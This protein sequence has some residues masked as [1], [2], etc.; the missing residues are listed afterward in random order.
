MTRAQ[1]GSGRG[2]VLV[3]SRSF[4]SGDQ[5]VQAEL[6]RAGLC[7]ARGPVDHDLT[8]LEEPL[9]SA[10][11]WIAGTGPVTADHLAAGRRLRVVARYGVGVDAV[12]L[13]AARSRHIVVTNTPGANSSSV[14]DHALALLLA[15]L[16]GVPAG[17]R[18]VRAGDWAVRRSHELGRLTVGIVGFGR[19]GQEVGRRLTGFGTRL[20]VHDPY[21]DPTIIERAGAAELGLAEM[22]ERCDL[23]TLHA[24]GGTTLVDRP[25]LESARRG[26]I[27]VNTARADLV[28]ESAA[29]DA[30][31]TGILGGYAG[32]TLRSEGGGAGSPLLAPDLADRVV[33]TPHLGAQ[34]VEAVDRMG[35]MA[36]ADVLAVLAGREPAHHV[37]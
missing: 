3:T 16:R 19:I 18:R 10:V 22:A 6:E 17:D 2:T 33:I 37:V 29:A 8:A 32:D 9:E 28:D 14:A 4:G 27:V 5:D 23:L 13:D 25:W 31:R 35:S 30:L 21:I 20:L 26:M 24:P 7:V 11:A 36:V 15:V 1:P 12:D 34:T